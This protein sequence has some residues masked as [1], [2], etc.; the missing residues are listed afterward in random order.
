LDGYSTNHE[1]VLS[2][3]M[4]G[5]VLAVRGDYAAGIAEGERA[6]NMAVQAGSL[7]GR[8]LSG[9][10]LSLIALAGGDNA[11]LLEMS[12]ATL[13]AAE[14]AG[15]HLLLYVANAD[16]AWAAS[17][18]GNHAAAAESMAR[19]KQIGEQSG[20]QLTFA[21]EIEVAS[22]EIALN[23]GRAAEAL[24]LSE[25]AAKSARSMED[26]Y[27]EGLAHRVW[28]IA[29]VA[30][31]PPQYDLSGLHYGESLRLFEE[32]DARLEAAR[33][34]A[35]WGK[36]LRQCGNES[37]AREHF[38]RAAAQFEKSGLER[39]LRETRQLFETLPK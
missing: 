35:A 8:G 38:E 3:G 11:R 2:H 23:A 39:E 21:D 22:A 7:T 5:W 32:G 9:M 1:A 36:M 30:V 27:A 14:K 16:R 25:R 10:C 17:R 37:A 20:G 12:R 6:L 33:T 4:L 26:I 34:H 28:A 13:D 24:E 19:S 29:L 15:D 18:A 31:D